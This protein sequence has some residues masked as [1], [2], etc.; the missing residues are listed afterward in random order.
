M[1]V[2]GDT[3]IAA[4]VRRVSLIARYGA[5]PAQI[6][7]VVAVAVFLLAFLVVPILRVILVAFTGADGY[8]SF[9][10]F[11]DFFASPLLRESLW[12]SVYVAVMTVALAS[13]IA[14]PLATLISRY[15]FRGAALIHTLGVIPL[16]MP[17]FVGAVAMQLI[18]GRNGAIN[19]LLLDWFG[20]RIPF[21]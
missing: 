7:A 20:F 9:V 4:P 16:V 12:N 6:I 14:V 13:L 5:S 3:P 11:G 8:F 21:M 17:P 1:A 2:L 15:R 18:Y 10:N 19:L